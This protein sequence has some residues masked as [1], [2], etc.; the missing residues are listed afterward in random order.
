MFFS[1]LRPTELL[2]LSI[3]SVQKSILFNPISNLLNIL[4][5][6]NLSFNKSLN[7]PYLEVDG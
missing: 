3:V 1:K 6:S 2:L 5:G 7:A 4:V